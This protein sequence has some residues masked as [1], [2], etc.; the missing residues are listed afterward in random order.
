M[1]FGVADPEFLYFTLI[2]LIVFPKSTEKKISAIFQCVPESE[3]Y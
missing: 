1:V 3:N 2:W